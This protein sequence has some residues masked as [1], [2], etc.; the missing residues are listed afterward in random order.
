MSLNK[1]SLCSFCVMDSSVPDIIFDKN[2]QCQYCKAHLKR[3]IFE[4]DNYSDYLNTLIE[5][6]KNNKNDNSYDCIIGV[7]GGVDSTYVAYYIK[8]ILKL[9]P[10]AVHL[11]NGWNSELAVQNIKS[12]LDILEIDLVTHVIDWNEFKLIQKSLLKS[13]I[14]NL[15]IAT[16]HAI[17]ALLI[18]TASKHKIKYIIN[19]SN[20]STEGIMPTSWME[21]NKNQYI[22]K[23]IFR[24]FYP[25]LKIKSLPTIS[26]IE[27]FYYFIIK[28]IKFIPILNFIEFDKNKA[29]KVLEK[30]IGYKPYR[31]KHFESIITRFFQGYILPRKFNIDKRK[32]HFSSLIISKQMKREEALKKLNED[33]AYGDINIMK[34][35]KIFFLK[36]L[37][38]DEKEFEEIINDK[39]KSASIYSPMSISLF[40]FLENFHHIIRWI[41]R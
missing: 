3:I 22:I 35:D 37:E 21:D 40:K 32:A 15:E 31:Y 1:N 16:D 34:R 6:I 7:S 8:K 5:K 2:Q 25:K 29:I 24:R 13:S 20:T 26:L 38:M 27:Y 28:K 18:K 39:P 4:K 41:T 36:K 17:N 10:L 12:C 19:G 30:E 23:S 11:D 9:N 14:N 33:N